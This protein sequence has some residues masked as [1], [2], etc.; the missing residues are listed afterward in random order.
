M[1]LE[2]SEEDAFYLSEL[3]RHRRLEVALPVWLTK[4]QEEGTGESEGQRED[5]WRAGRTRDISMGGARVIV[6][7]QAGN[8]HD[9]AGRDGICLVHFAVTDGDDLGHIPGFLKRVEHSERSGRSLLSIEFEPG[10]EEAK[11]AAI[12]SGLRILRARRRWQAAFSGTR[13]T[14]YI[15]RWRSGRA[16]ARAEAHAE[17]RAEQEMQEQRQQDAE[18]Q[19]GLGETPPPTPQ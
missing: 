1:A 2:L 19:P 8:W 5:S 7:S 9:I 14:G 6:P 17:A 4:P 16:E 15:A 12:W 3:R 10:A 11:I 18:Q 13:Q